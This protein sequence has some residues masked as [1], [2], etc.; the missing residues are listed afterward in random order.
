MGIKFSDVARHPLLAT[1]KIDEVISL[2]PH[3]A[4]NTPLA[5]Y[6]PF[7]TVNSDKIQM[8]VEK[9]LVG[10]MTPVASVGS[11]SPIFGR[12]GRA[13]REFEAAEW[14]EKCILLEHELVDFRKIGTKNQLM[15]ARERLR[16]KYEDL[17]TRLAY[18]LEW[19]RYQVL[20]EGAVTGTD[21][22]GLEITLATYNHPSHLEYTASTTWSNT[23]T[24]TPL[25]DLQLWAE[26]YRDYSGYEVDDVVLPHGTLRLLTANQE[27]RDIVKNSYGAFKGSQ[28]AVRKILLEYLG[29]GSISESAGRLP[30]M[31]E[32]TADAAAAQ[33]DVVLRDVGNLV[34]GDMVI[35][36]S[37]DQKSEQLTIASISGNTVTFTANLAN[38]YSAGSVAKWHRYLI[39]AGT[40]LITGRPMMS[41][42]TA[43]QEAP[44]NEELRSNW[45]AV[46]STLSRYADMDNPKSGVFR[47]N[48]DKL[49]ADPPRLEQVIGVKALP[50][51]NYNEGWAT[52]SI[53]F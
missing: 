25:N 5:K 12:H 20:F 30:H 53:V 35:L 11:E 19:M 28:E 6:F 32:L 4:M 23:A 42:M 40:A 38:A 37:V 10:G 24:A 39:P 46:V 44:V 16:Q 1:D 14:R 18:R 2:F 36:K 7:K 3:M 26:H 17:E 47:K 21:P 22:N 49:G 33:T 29:V 31:T 13:Y 50:I 15:T 41:V 27:F 51:V 52:A 8:D 9:T 34:A 45:G 48:I 43:G